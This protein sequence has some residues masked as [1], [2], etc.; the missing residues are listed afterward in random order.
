M[1]EEINSDYV[2]KYDVLRAMVLRTDPFRFEDAAN[3]KM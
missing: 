1:F 2:H 3:S